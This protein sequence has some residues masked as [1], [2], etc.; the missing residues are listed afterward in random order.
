MIEL[1]FKEYLRVFWRQLLICYLGAIFVASVLW[2]FYPTN[3]TCKVCDAYGYWKSSES[4]DG[5]KNSHN[6]L[7]TFFYPSFIAFI[8][9]IPNYLR[10]S[11]EVQAFLVSIVQ[12]S[13]HLLSVTALGYTTYLLTDN[14]FITSCTTY[15]YGLNIFIIAFTNQMLAD[16]ISISYLLIVVTFFVVIILN[17]LKYKKLIIVFGLLNGLL[18]MTRLSFALAAISLYTICSFIYIYKNHLKLNSFIVITL[19]LMAFL[20]PV[21]FQLWLTPKILSNWAQL[22]ITISSLYGVHIYKSVGIVDPNTIHEMVV[23]GSFDQTMKTFA[24]SCPNPQSLNN[25]I[26]ERLTSSPLPVSNFDVF[27]WY[28]IK[29]FAM[30]DKVFLSPFIYNLFAPERYIWRTINSLF[31]SLSILGTIQ[32][33]R[34]VF[35]NTRK[36]F[37][38]LVIVFIILLSLLL[39]PISYVLVEERYGL[40]FHSFF[41]ISTSYFV[42]YFVKIRK[43]KFSQIRLSVLFLIIGLFL[44]IISLKI[45]SMFGLRL[46]PEILPP[47]EFPKQGVHYL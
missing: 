20:I 24:A 39:P 29:F 21:F 16:S 27:K 12:L 46:Y 35:K 43:T 41:A 30:H 8:R 28:V 19:G 11:V 37:V 4:F 15:L 34:N 3:L 47:P 5:I 6:F 36:Y 44:F 31:L 10:I 45:E 18:L 7:G 32:L 33:L 26:R 1:S 38:Y 40:P 23:F 22:K 13:V 25:C 14:K 2:Y 17:P 42:F 9:Y